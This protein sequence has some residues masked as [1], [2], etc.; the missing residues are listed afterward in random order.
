MPLGFLATYGHNEPADYRPVVRRSKEEVQTSS[1]FAPILNDLPKVEDI[2]QQMAAVEFPPLAALLNH[3]VRSGG[4][5]VRPAIVLLCAKFRDYPLEQLAP[6]AAAVELLHTAS[7]V[8][9]D[10]IDDAETRRGNPTLNVIA[11][12]RAPILVGDYI[13]AKSAMMAVLGEN[14]RVMHEFASALMQICEGELR[15]VLSSHQW[16]QTREEYDY[17]ISCKTAALFRLS[18]A[19]GAIL[20]GINE[21][22]VVALREYGH[23]LGMAFQIVDDILDFT[24]DEHKLG[25]PVGGDLRQG[26]IT[27]PMIYHLDSAPDDSLVRAVLDRDNHH[28][29]ADI[30]AAIKLIVDSPA[31]D[32]SYADAR[33][34]VNLAKQALVSLPDGV[35][36]QSLEGLADYSVERLA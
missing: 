9:D 27:L 25:K 26:T 13:F 12:S 15:E 19:C 17:K 11:G 2:L 28:T 6:V 36:R 29:D 31:I 5:R 35:Y 16:P 7:L 18:A 1:L 34:Y 21:S 20:S 33:Q 4:K 3:M 32:Q 24:G 8:H 22:S 10:V 30:V 23:N 14:L